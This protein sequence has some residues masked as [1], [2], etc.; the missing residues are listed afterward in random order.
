[1]QQTPEKPRVLIVNQTP[2]PKDARATLEAKTLVNAGYDV[3]VIC[4][5]WDPADPS[6][7]EIDG[8]HIYSY[9][10]PREPEGL[11]GHFWEFAYCW[12]KSAILSWRIAR[13][14]GFDLVHACN[15]PDSFFLLGALYKPFGKRFVFAQHDLVPELWLSRFGDRGLTGRVLHRGLLAMEQFSYRVADGVVVPN[16]S[17]KGVATTRGHHEPDDVAVVR[18]APMLDKVTLC[19]PDPTLKC[20]RKHLV[21]YLGVM[22][23]Q[24]GV[25]YLVRAVAH[26]VHEMGRTDTQFVLVGSGDCEEELK[27]QAEQLDVAEYLTFAGWISDRDEL[28][29]Y[30]RSADVCVAPDPKT[31]LNEKSSFLKVTDYM[32]AGRPTVAFDLPETRVSAA[33][34]ALYAIPDDVADLAERIVELLDDPDR[35]ERMGRQARERIEQTLSWP[36]QEPALLELYGKLL[37]VE[38]NGHRATSQDASD[39]SVRA[40]RAPLVCVD[41]VEDKR[42]FLDFWGLPYSEAPENQGDVRLVSRADFDTDIEHA[43]VTLRPDSAPGLHRTDNGCAF[44]APVRHIESIPEG[45]R[46]VSRVYDEHGTR[47]SYVLEDE[48]RRAFYLPFELDAA[49]RGFEREEYARGRRFPPSWLLSVYYAAK[50]LIPAAMRAR[51]R[52]S[53]ARVQ[54]ESTSFPAWP[55]DTSSEELRRFVLRLLLRA[56]RAGEL[57]VVWFW[58]EG[59]DSCLVLTHDVERELVDNPGI[60]RIIDV[61]KRYGFRSSF[62]VVPF[63]YEVTEQALD[64]LRDAGC[65]VGVHGY[66][67]DGTLFR[68]RS[69]FDSRAREINEIGRQWGAA[70]FRS[71]S[72]Y[73]DPELIGGLEFEYDASYF[74]TDPYEPQPGGCLSLFPYFLDEK[75]E[76]P[77]T[78]CQDHTLLVV[79]DAQDIS[80]WR[81][82]IAAIRALN[83]MVCVNA[84]P[85]EGYIGDEDKVHHYD[86][87]L[88]GLAG[89]ERLWNPH[90]HELASWWKARRDAGVAADSEGVALLADDDRM[91]L[92]WARLEE[93]ELVFGDASTEW[94][95]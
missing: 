58:P 61:E 62:N 66:S 25:D 67:H 80:V 72:T 15:P 54:K 81:D 92:K 87:L 45:M 95:A 50:P 13:N 18:N 29:R 64:R 32:V 79:T 94:T 74:D 38:P 73:R 63:K 56:S 40:Q 21:A 30:L 85:D 22:N 49:F 47:V 51:G 10:P 83:A 3:S 84:H 19:D 44:F 86:E 20:G 89:D 39:P 52:K 59:K 14:G 27:E 8:M 77:M 24:D 46:A 55:T 43:V 90:A 41:P 88:E 16:D 17:Y 11:L 82:K 9:A 4:S 6:Y 48:E 5:K 34:T 91:C 57:P 71:A 36:H 2:V 65:E 53:F 93:D 70:G 28:S 78:V 33:D 26:L 75:V 69:K 1:M 37:P 68:D 60:G 7:D 76:I 42:R 12:T 31:P 35:R 23:P